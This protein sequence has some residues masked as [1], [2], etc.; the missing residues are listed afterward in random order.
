MESLQHERLHMVFDGL[1]LYA[2]VFINGKLAGESANALVP[3]VFDVKPFVT[4]GPNEVIVRL[5]VG[6]ELARDETLP[7]QGKEW[8]SNSA[9]GGAI[10]NPMRDGDL[11]G[12]RNWNG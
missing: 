8:R 5:T 1:D 3:S 2:Q 11:Y 10:P 12:H 9:A 7:G 4:A 6:S